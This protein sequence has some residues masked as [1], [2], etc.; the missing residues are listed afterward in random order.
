[1]HRPSDTA[2]IFFCCRRGLFISFLHSYRRSSWLIFFPTEDLICQPN[3][4]SV[5]ICSS[6][7]SVCL[8]P[9]S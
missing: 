5:R 1:M 9:K 3:L 4:V 7:C 6:A 2:S 8:P